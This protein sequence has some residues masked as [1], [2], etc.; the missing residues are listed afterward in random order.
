MDQLLVII[1]FIF[2]G[3]G[4][5]FLWLFVVYMTV[6]TAT[7]ARHQAESKLRNQ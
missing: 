5:M 2:S 6:H 3:I 1:G 4:I 7:T